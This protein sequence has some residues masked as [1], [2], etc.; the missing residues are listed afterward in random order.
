MATSIEEIVGFLQS[1][2][3][4]HEVDGDYIRTGFHTEKYR[5]PDGDDGVRV[6]IALEENGEF[7]KIVA[8]MIY[9]YPEGPHKAVLFQLLLMVS[10]DTKMIQYEYDM[11]DGEVRATIEFPIEDSKLTKAQLMRCVHW[12]AAATD[13]YHEDLVAA[14]TK[15]ELPK[16]DEDDSE[17]AELWAEFQ[18]FLEQ[19]K[20]GQ[21][22][23]GHGLPS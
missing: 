5:D 9:K 15:G 23:D 17:V 12:I 3:I 19:R 18:E 13:K 10:W 8:P 11:N 6:V 1:D 21:G 7:L 2:G 22:G 4:K 16:R 20:R 14:M